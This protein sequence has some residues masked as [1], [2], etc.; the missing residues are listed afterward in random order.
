MTSV[1]L[2]GYFTAISRL[3]RTFGGLTN[4]QYIFN[5]TLGLG[6]A[7]ATNSASVGLL[8]GRLGVSIGATGGY[9]NVFRSISVC[10]LFHGT[11]LPFLRWFGAVVARFA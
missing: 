10:G 11:G 3:R 6:L 4:L 7:I 5:V 9:C 1:L 2:K 8:F